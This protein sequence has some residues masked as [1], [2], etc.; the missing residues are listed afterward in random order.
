MAYRS[1]AKAT[2]N[3]SPG[4]NGTQ[5]GHPLSDSNGD[6]HYLEKPTE[7]GRRKRGQEKG[8]GSNGTDLSPSL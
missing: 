4:R 7:G 6:I 5:R 2:L 1:P 3:R 8:S